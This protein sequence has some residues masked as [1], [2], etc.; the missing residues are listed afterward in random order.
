M[1]KNELNVVFDHFKEKA[2]TEMDRALKKAIRKTAKELQERT[3]E[4]A[5]AGIKTHNNHVSTADNYE[6]DDIENAV[7][8]SKLQDRYDEDDIYMK[9]HVMGNGKPNSKT[10]RF[11]FLEKGTRERSYIDKKGTQHRLGRIVGKRYFGKAKRGID[12]YPIFEA[13]I[14]KAIRKV[15]ETA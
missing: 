11:R 5:K 13:E 14:E 8:V 3:K 9:V 2:Y 12:P 1:Y 7:M 4:N 15:N 10:F 6:E